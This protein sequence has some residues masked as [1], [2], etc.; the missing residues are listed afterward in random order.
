MRHATPSPAALRELAAQQIPFVATGLCDNWAARNWQ[1]QTLS[2]SFGA[3]P[4]CIRLHRRDNCSSVPYEGECTYVSATIGEFCAWLL[5]N[6]ASTGALEQYSR[7]AW[8]AYC[9]YQEMASLFADEPAALAAVDWSSV[10]GE[11]QSA[12]PRDGSHTTLWLGSGDASTPLHYDTYGGANWIAQLVGTKRWRLHP[13]MSGREEEPHELMR[14][15]RVPY[16]ESS[17]FAR[18][19]ASGSALPDAPMASNNP[20][21]LPS[22]GWIEFEL[23]PG[24][25]LHVPRH[26]WHAVYT[27]SDHALSVN[28]WIDE[29]MADIP[30][31][32]R[33]ASARLVA[34][35][36]VR[37]ARECSRWKAAT[38]VNEEE[39]REEEVVLRR[40]LLEPP[41]GWTNPTEEL[42]PSCAADLE[43]LSVAMAAAD[44]MEGC[45][46]CAVEEGGGDGGGSEEVAPLNTSTPARPLTCAAAAR[47]ICLGKPMEVAARRL[48]SGTSGGGEQLRAPLA[49]LVRCA[50]L[51]SSS[52]ATES[53][54]GEIAAATQAPPPFAI[55]LRR[56][57]A[58]PGGGLLTLV[59]VIDALCTEEGLDA[60]V[61]ALQQASQR[62]A[63]G[64][65]KRDRMEVEDEE[66]AHEPGSCDCDTSCVV[67]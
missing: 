31:R 66:C 46:E 34:C 39:A 18:E 19:R 4:T 49:R 9:D 16:E 51:L 20:P 2:N 47:A 10:L 57:H 54:G 17:V 35:S 60:V 64:G 6:H 63:A 3:V 5:G 29:P 32:V 1:L 52:S 53:T 23:Q 45:T 56:L 59:D 55:A 40:M 61:E 62:L 38:G 12:A 7:E 43:L 14:P 37:G 11:E 26:W 27:T 21:H 65:N 67:S 25:V 33:E 41:C 48:A 24:D 44:A 8:I 30:E 15:S 28:T 50:L 22:S 36:L 42:S 13:P 58:A